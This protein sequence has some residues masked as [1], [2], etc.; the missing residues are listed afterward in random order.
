[1]SNWRTYVYT[2]LVVF[3]AALLISSLEQPWENAITAG[4]AVAL[5]LWVY[6]Q[7]KGRK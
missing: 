4:S 2:G 1:M 7:T 6:D 5:G 3:V